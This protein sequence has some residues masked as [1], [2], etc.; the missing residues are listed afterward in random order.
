MSVPIYKSLSLYSKL[1]YFLLTFQVEKFSY[2][3]TRLFSSS[4]LLYY[5][6]KSE[7]SFNLLLSIQLDFEKTNCSSNGDGLVKNTYLSR[8]EKMS[9]INA[10]GIESLTFCIYICVSGK[11][12]VI[13][14]EEELR[15]QNSY[16][17]IIYL[18]QRQPRS[19]LAEY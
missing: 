7:K 17:S 13:F 3:H 4:F 6:V 5:I 9:M 16:C 18:L 12:S 10:Y 8:D 15:G 14:V 1:E 2:I 11:N 19:I